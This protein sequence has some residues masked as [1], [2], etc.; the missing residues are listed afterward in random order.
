M[1]KVYPKPAK[2]LSEGPGLF[3]LEG[4]EQLLMQ[5]MAVLCQFF[6]R[7]TQNY[8]TTATPKLALTLFTAH[9]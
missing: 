8:N 3:T 4:F 1:I 7:S 6:G 9:T 2:A 5:E